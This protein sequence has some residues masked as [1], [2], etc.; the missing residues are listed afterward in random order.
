MRA[1][2]VPGAP[3]ARRAALYRSFRGV[4]F[5]TDPTGVAEGRSP[6][7]KNLIPDKSGFP[8]KRPGWR[9]VGSYGAEIR[10]IH[11]LSTEGSDKLIVHAGN[12]LY[13]H[14]ET[15]V[16]LFETASVG[17]SFS[18]VC[19][20][21]LWIL[22]GEEY[23][24]FDGSGI[25]RVS[26]IAY[27]PT[28]VIS[29]PPAG[30]GAAFEPVNL[31]TGRRKNRFR[32]DGVS[33]LYAL[34]SE[35][36]DGVC[37][38][39]V[40]G[41]VVD[42]ALYAVDAAAGTV[43]F[44]SAPPAPSTPGEDNVVVAF[45]K[46][47]PG[48]A[49]AVER[50]R[51]MGLFGLGGANSDRIFFSGNPERQNVDWHCDI[52][53]PAYDVDPTY[54]PDTS[55]AYVGSDGNAIMG[56]RRLGA[57]QLIVKAQNDQDAS[58]FL[59]SSALDSAGNTAFGLTQGAVGS[60]AVS[61][62]AFATLRDE[63]LFL[64]RDGVCG[65]VTSAVT[66]VTSIQNRSYFVDRALLSEPGLENAVAV[67]WNGLYLLCV[68][69]RCYV[70]DGTQ[71]RA[72]PEKAVGSVCECCY[73]TNIPASCFCEA[74]GTLWFGT[75]DGRLCR[76][77]TDIGGLGRYSD[78]GYGIEAVWST[79]ADDGGDFGR[80]K[81][82]NPRWCAVMVKPG[83]HAGARV[84]LSAQKASA[85]LLTPES[86]N[87]FSYDGLPYEDFRFDTYDSLEVFPLDIRVKDYVTLQIIVK[88]EAANENFG[89]CGI[90]KR[91]VF[92]SYVKR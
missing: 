45:S 71:R 84:Y 74:G 32:G 91:F 57:Y 9:T 43:T 40:G 77:N 28:T 12:A 52:S 26:D 41:E 36:I 46:T 14:G 42:P 86:G 24:C 21:K 31:L 34:D 63:P 78:D 61:M 5:S 85:R 10:G 39:S 48:N 72:Y 50:C 25:K 65:V 6:Y 64:T 23:L 70:L 49:A 1:A 68:N 67:E 54:V 75:A 73:W 37:E 16:K 51:F 30:G 56:Y 8:E 7:A 20:G 35:G 89:V 69:S 17:K 11:R 22:T 15:P 62:Y 60:G 47:V 4:D 90:I 13:L 3:R 38:V 79:R 76:F 33:T 92:N 82:L 88:N 27:A 58:L 83:T 80:T 59:R 81:T 53:A 29:A 55:Y 2:K 87:G 19:A 44:S 66:N 18:L